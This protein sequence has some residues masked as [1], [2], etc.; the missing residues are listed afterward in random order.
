[1]ASDPITSW[2][3]DGEEVQTVTG[4]L[5]WGFKITENGDFSHVINRHLLLGRKAMT[6]IDSTLKS[7][8]Y[9]ADKGLSSQSYGFSSS[10][11]YGYESWTIKK[12]ECHRINAFKLWCWKRLL[13][14]RW[15]ARKS[16]QSILKEINP[17]HALEGLMLKLQYFGHPMQ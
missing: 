13:R 12:T 7:R 9:F 10:P 5:L 15:T 14:V 2:Q 16:N 8:H 1:M 11:T 4:F 6:K 17:E 3:T